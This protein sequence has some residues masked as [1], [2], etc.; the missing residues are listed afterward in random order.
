[1]KSA[2]QK[3]NLVQFLTP[4]SLRRWWTWPA[5][6]CVSRL[7]HTI[8]AFIREPLEQWTMKLNELYTSLGAYRNRSMPSPW[9]T[10]QQENVYHDICLLVNNQKDE[11][12]KTYTNALCKILLVFMVL[13]LTVRFEHSDHLRTTM[14]FEETFEQNVQ[15]WKKAFIDAVAISPLLLILYPGSGEHISISLTLQVGGQLAS[16]RKPEL[17]QCI[18]E[19]LWRCIIGVAWGC[20]TSDTGLTN[21]LTEAAPLIRGDSEGADTWFSDAFAA[22]VQCNQILGLEVRVGLANV[23]WLNNSRNFEGAHK[24]HCLLTLQVEQWGH[25]HFPV[26]WPHPPNTGLNIND[27]PTI[28]LGQIGEDASRKQLKQDRNLAHSETMVESPPILEVQDRAL[29]DGWYKCCINASVSLSVAPA[30]ES[31]L[32]YRLDFDLAINN[33]VCTLERFCDHNILVVGA[34]TSQITWTLSS[35]SKIGNP[36]ANRDFQDHQGQGHDMRLSLCELHEE[37]QENEGLILTTWE[38]SNRRLLTQSASFGWRGILH[39][40][41]TS[42]IQVHC[43]CQL[44]YLFQHRV[45]KHDKLIHAYHDWDSD[46]INDPKQ[47]KA[48][49]VVLEPG[50]VLGQHFYTTTTLSKTVSGWVDTYIHGVKIERVLYFQLRDLL[51]RLILYLEDGLNTDSIENDSSKFKVNT[52]EGLLDIVALGNLLLS[53]PALDIVAIFDARKP[54]AYWPLSK[55]RW[56]YFDIIYRLQEQYSLILFPDTPLAHDAFT[57]PLDSLVSLRIADFAKTS[58]IHFAWS[59]ILSARKAQGW[60]KVYLKAFKQP[61]FFV[62]PRARPLDATVDEW[63]VMVVKERVAEVMQSPD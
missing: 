56:A 37:S 2:P 5:S 62:W 32:V 35:L 53:L 30:V 60:R 18:E 1:M 38:F 9:A 3:T 22:L 45:K 44:W 55:G 31:A 57:K 24:V 47:W 4:L 41:P 46:F 49:V 8:P 42:V 12:I 61:T 52:A 20:W 14:I 43:G 11:S 7:I 59:L 27:L 13:A 17:L 39:P 25:R 29:L 63:A 33:P 23:A 15:R 21:F 34:K 54:D 36:D 6:F 58:A 28:E 19:M 16:Y 48:E 50:N 51:F 26:L 40:P 10:N